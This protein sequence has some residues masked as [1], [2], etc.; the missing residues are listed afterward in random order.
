MDGSATP[1]LEAGEPDEPDKDGAP[2]CGPIETAV[3]GDI[4]RL[5]ELT[6]IQ[7]S[8]AATAASL[9]RTL[10]TGEGAQRAMLAREL[11][12][13]LR[14]LA[15]VNAAEDAAARLAAELSSPLKDERDA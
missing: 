1:F 13:T 3:R 10:D 14:A 12:E 9:A 8:L 11:R 6:G 7:P 15:E 4:A 5:G 2:A